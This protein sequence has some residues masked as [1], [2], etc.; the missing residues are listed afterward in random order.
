MS[1]T[2]N[3]V[4]TFPAVA[5]DS[6]LGDAGYVAWGKYNTA[7]TELYTGTGLGVANLDP[8][9][10]TDSAAGI[11][12]AITALAVIGGGTVTLHTGLFRCSTALT[13]P[14]GVTLFSSNFCPSNTYSG[15]GI[16]ERRLLF[17]LSVPSFV[18]F[19]G[20]T[21]EYA[22]FVARGILICFAPGTPHTYPAGMLQEPT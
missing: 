7:I 5:I 8:T 17:V 19:G 6:N 13:I 12:A 21:A 10:S 2:A 14:A 20:I 3:T 15:S 16:P 1:L 22:C 11:Q 9:G 18:F 4:I